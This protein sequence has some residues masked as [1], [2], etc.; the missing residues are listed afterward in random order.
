MKKIITAICG[1]MAATGAM[2]AKEDAKFNVVSGDAWKTTANFNSTYFTK[3]LSN[4]FMKSWLLGETHQAG[5]CGT[6][7]E[8]AGVAIIATDIFTNGNGAEFCTRQI[9][10]ANGGAKSWIDI[11]DTKGYNKCNVFCKKGYYGPKCDRTQRNNCDTTN[12]TEKFDDVMDNATINKLLETTS[13]YCD[14]ES[15]IKTK[16]TPAFV[17]NI[18]LNH[19]G[20]KENASNAVVLGVLDVKEHAIIVGPVQINAIRKKYS[21]NDSWISAV[22]GNGD[23]FVLCAEGYEQNKDGTDCELSYWCSGVTP[24]CSGENENL[25][26]DT[27]HD[28]ETREENGEV[29]KYIVCKSGYGFKEGTRNCIE[30]PETKDS[31]V[32]DNG[33]CKKCESGEMFKDGGCHRYKTYSKRELIKG[34]QD[35]YDCWK[36]TKPADYKKCVTCE[37]PDT[38]NADTKE[39]R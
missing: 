19:D 25:F 30:C 17:S 39:C 34:V 36:E 20:G 10:S 16:N 33:E 32:F 35:L 22:S 9:Q 29:C 15:K 2:A 4:R 3:D 1:I 31:G 38:Y 28:W 13:K 5:A 12:Y 37:S 18:N 26:D 21:R 24:V 7:D 27:L 11:Y 14:D 6:N 8:G 23:E